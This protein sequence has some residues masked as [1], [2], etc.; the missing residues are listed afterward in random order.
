MR[1]L[2]YTNCQKTYTARGGTGYNVSLVP[3]RLRTYHTFMT[4]CLIYII[5]P[6]QSHGRCDDCM[7]Y[8]TCI[9]CGS[10]C[11]YRALSLRVGSRQL[12]CARVGTGDPGPIQGPRG[13]VNLDRCNPSVQ[14]ARWTVS[15]SDRPWYKAGPT[16]PH[17]GPVGPRKH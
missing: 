3:Y 1:L 13:Q 12:R 10:L 2:Q 6:F 17:C 7:K 16:P 9:R 15:V 11:P 14:H 4:V 8:D 5:M